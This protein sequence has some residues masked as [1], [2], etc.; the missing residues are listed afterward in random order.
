MQ[1]LEIKTK[2]DTIY[3]FFYL[4]KMVDDR[5]F[6][7]ALTGMLYVFKNNNTYKLLSSHW[8]V[9]ARTEFSLLPKQPLNG[10]KCM[11]KCVASYWPSSGQE[12]AISERQETNKTVLQLTQCI[13]E[14]ELQ[15]QCR[16]GKP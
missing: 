13:A 7:L 14:I 3:S 2:L 9:I 5:P 1:S 16:E 10:G 11:K 6:C 8:L 15:L 4:K 12:T